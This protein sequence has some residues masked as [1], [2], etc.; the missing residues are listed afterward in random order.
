MV[1]TYCTQR[2]RWKVR[3]LGTD[4]ARYACGTCRQMLRE[5]HLVALALRWVSHRPDVWAVT[6]QELL[7]RQA[8]SGQL[9]SWEPMQKGG[10]S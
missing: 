9:A 3:L 2:A 6:A 4:Q 10:R 7:E 8:R 1:C 5:G